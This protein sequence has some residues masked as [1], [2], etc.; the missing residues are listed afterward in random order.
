MGLFKTKTI[1]NAALGIWKIEEATGELYYR[2]SLSGSEQAYYA[3]LRSP[4]RRKHWLSYRLILPHLLDPMSVSGI[5]YDQYGKPHLDNGEGH[6]SVAH[7]GIYSALIVSRDKAVGID[8]ESMHE[9]IFKLTHK[10]LS[11]IEQQYK[12]QDSAM[13]SL[14]LIWCSKE[15][16]YKLHGKRGL[17]FRE[18]I[19]ID[20]FE[21]KGSGALT[22]RIRSDESNKSYGLFYE[23]IGNYM[24]VY[25]IDA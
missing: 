10:F 25:A 14:Y 19:H 16:L 1:K 23:C 12:L 21:F 4:L 13:E 17:S 9:K 8:I 24:L 22:G 3:A 5:S 6:I 11:D 2:A 20:P 15:A 18:H 7:S